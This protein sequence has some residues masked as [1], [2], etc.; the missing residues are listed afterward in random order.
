MLTN[1]FIFNTRDPIVVG[2][3]VENGIVKEGTPLCVP[4]KEV[5]DLVLVHFLSDLN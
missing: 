1:Q 5:R 4:S 3:V 2:V